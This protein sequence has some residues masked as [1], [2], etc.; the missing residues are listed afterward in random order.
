MRNIDDGSEIF[1]FVV[2]DAL[3]RRIYTQCTVLVTKVKIGCCRF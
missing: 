3:K 2:P 1:Q